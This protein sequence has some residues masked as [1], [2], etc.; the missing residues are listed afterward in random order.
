MNADLGLSQVTSL[1][2]TD[3]LV[4]LTVIET[5]FCDLGQWWYITRSQKRI[6]VLITWWNIGAYLNR[7][8]KSWI[9]FSS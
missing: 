9:L 8:P 6:S 5:N 3:M 4:L 7:V 2:D 1:L